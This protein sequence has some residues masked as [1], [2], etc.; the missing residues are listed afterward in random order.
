MLKSCSRCKQKKADSEFYRRTKT[1][2][3]SWCKDCQKQLSRNQQRAHYEGAGRTKHLAAK[4]GITEDRYNA[5]LATQGGLC[6]ICTQAEVGRRLSVDHDHATGRVRGLLC[7]SCN[8]MVGSA[9]DLPGVLRAAAAYL[10]GSRV[11]A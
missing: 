7:R 8:L 9:K 5:L 2:R 6:S 3:F 4:Y 10:E 11:G 1:S